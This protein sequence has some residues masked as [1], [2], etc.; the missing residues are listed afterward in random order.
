MFFKTSSTGSTSFS[1]G[2]SAHYSDRLCDFSVTIPRCY[3]VFSGVKGQKMAQNDKKFC[4]FCSISQEPYTIWSS[5]VVLMCKMIISPGI[6][7]IFQNFDSSGWEGQK[8]KKN[9]PKYVIWLWFFL[10]TCKIMTS[11]DGFFIFS[12]FLFAGLLVGEGGKLMLNLVISFPFV[13]HF[14]ECKFC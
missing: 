14:W 12:K 13:L 1:L 8:S 11:P 7:F 6:F 2:R 10:H 9:D 4:L 5:F 3:K